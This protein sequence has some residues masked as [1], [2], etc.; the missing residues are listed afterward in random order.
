[1]VNLLMPLSADLVHDRMVAQWLDAM[2]TAELAAHVGRIQ[3]VLHA[4][5]LM[6]AEHAG[7]LQT[8]LEARANG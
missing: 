1:M 2:T 3:A 4:K 7:R 5:G 6:G 8:L